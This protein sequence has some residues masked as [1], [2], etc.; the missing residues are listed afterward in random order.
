MQEGALPATEVRELGVVG[1]AALRTDT[2][3]VVLAPPCS[4]A[5][6][7]GAMLGQH[8][9][10]FG[11]PETHLFACET[12]SQ[13]LELS[14]RE[15]FNMAH[16]LLR[17][18]AQLCF[19]GQAEGQIVQARGWLRRR[20]HL[21]TG[22]LIEELAEMVCP[23]TIVDKSPST[24]YRLDSLQRIRNMFP[25]AS[26]LHLVQHPRQYAESVMKALRE[27]AAHGPVPGWL[28]NLA[29]GRVTS[30]S[31]VQEGAVDPQN[32]WHVLHKNISEFLAT[33]PEHQKFLL[34]SEDLFAYPDENLASIAGWLGMRKDREVIEAMKQPERSPFA[35][36][37][38]EN[39]HHGDD[40]F[41]LSDPTAKF[42]QQ[43]PQSLEGPLNWRTDGG[44]F[45]SEVK[46]LA[47]NFGYA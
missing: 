38:P 33:V 17:L 34:R 46:E 13:W 4:C 3:L 42:G 30:D 18:V 11:L 22:Y 7:V 20:A 37:G 23:R 14:A 8:P 16:G 39:A 47:R 45:I 41:F 31:T 32:A 9:E 5:S 6:V 29:S 40:H 44:E 28:L 43:T 26:F 36:F 24:V 35:C 10:M 25:Q 12:V 27:A 19:G 15:T 21:T 1:E 2:I